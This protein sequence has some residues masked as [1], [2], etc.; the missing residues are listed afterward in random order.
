MADVSANQ[1]EWWKYAIVAVPAI[2][3]AGSTIASHD[4]YPVKDVPEGGIFRRGIDSVK[5]WFD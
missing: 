1:R 5:L 2:V 3:V 4:L